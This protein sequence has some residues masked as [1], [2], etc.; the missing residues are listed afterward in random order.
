MRIIDPCVTYFLQLRQARKLTAIVCRN[1]EEHSAETVAEHS[2]LQFSEGFY[3]R[4][5]FFVGQFSNEGTACLA[6][7]QSQQYFVI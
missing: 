3:H 1:A 7:N 2:I 6:L 5:T 4:G